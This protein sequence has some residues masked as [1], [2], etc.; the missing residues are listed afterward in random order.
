MLRAIRVPEPVIARESGLNHIS[1]FYQG[2]G[3]CKPP[4]YSAGGV[5]KWQLLG[6]RLQDFACPLLWGTGLW[7]KDAPKFFRNLEVEF[8]PF[9]YSWFWD[10]RR[11]RNGSSM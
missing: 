5:P 9:H 10:W 8:C 6:K 2:L 1:C 4:K 7:P 3:F 11:R